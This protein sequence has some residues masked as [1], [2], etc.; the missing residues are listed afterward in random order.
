M[1]IAHNQDLALGGGTPWK[2]RTV[3]WTATEAMLCGVTVFNLMSEATCEQVAVESFKH[4][5]GG[6]SLLLQPP[7]S[8]MNEGELNSDL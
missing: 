6:G 5:R 3:T 2:S 7:P 8:V 1:K 4:F